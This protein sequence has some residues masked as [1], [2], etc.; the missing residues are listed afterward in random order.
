MDCRLSVPII[1][2]AL[3]RVGVYKCI[4]EYLTRLRCANEKMVNECKVAWK[5][6][7]R[8]LNIIPKL[9]FTR[10]LYVYNMDCLLKMYNT[11][12]RKQTPSSK[13]NI[14]DAL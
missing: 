6:K 3:I 9:C 5:I 11:M 8:L 14:L 2:C 7:T 4:D 10:Y 12:K 1:I 13:Y